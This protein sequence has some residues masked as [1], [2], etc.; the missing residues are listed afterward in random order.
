[1]QIDVLGQ[2]L[3]KVVGGQQYRGCFI[4]NEEEQ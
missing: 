3:G 2:Q 4:V 1:M